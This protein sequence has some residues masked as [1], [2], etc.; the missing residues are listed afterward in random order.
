MNRDN[1]QTNTVSMFQW[2]YHT[3]TRNSLHR[4]HSLQVTRGQGHDTLPLS[5]P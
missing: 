5:C 4:A 2:M 3:N 1:A